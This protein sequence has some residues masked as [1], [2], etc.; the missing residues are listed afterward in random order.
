MPKLDGTRPTSPQR[1]IC[2]RIAGKFAATSIFAKVADIEGYPEVAGCSKTLL[3][4]ETGHAHGHLDF[5]KQVGDPGDGQADRRHAQET[6]SQPSPVKPTSTSRCTGLRQNRARRRLRRNRGVEKSQAEA[7]RKPAP[8]SA[9]AGQLRSTEQSAAQPSVARLLDASVR[10]LGLWPAFSNH[11]AISA[12]PSSRAVLA[13]PGLHR[14][15]LV[16]FTGDG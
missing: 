12:K 3:D 8:R 15:V 10:L 9:S 7:G 1:S 16:G 5:L 2:R 4:G 11:S 13:K 14:L 6:C